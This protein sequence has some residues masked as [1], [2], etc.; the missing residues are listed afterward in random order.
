MIYGGRRFVAILSNRLPTTA[1]GNWVTREEMEEYVDTHCSGV[2]TGS[3][4][5]YQEMVD[6]VDSHCTCSG[7]D[8]SQEQLDEIYTWITTVSGRV[9]CWEEFVLG[10][11]NFDNLTFDYPTPSGSIDETHYW[12]GGPGF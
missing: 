12:E 11:Q 6:Y 1:S 3:G 5:T 9:T 8:I 4:V 2:V 7:G 10:L